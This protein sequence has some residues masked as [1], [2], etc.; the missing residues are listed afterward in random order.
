MPEIRFRDRQYTQLQGESV[1]EC[2][3]RHGVDAPHSCR[4]GVCQTCMMRATDGEL[5]A[6]AQ[7][8]L[9]PASRAQGFFLPCVCRENDDLVISDQSDSR[10][11]PAR[12]ISKEFLNPSVI[13]LQL[14]VE[15]DDF[16]YHAGQFV[17]VRREDRLTRSYSLASLPSAPYLELHV[18]YIQDGR[19]SGWIRDRLQPGD[20]L[21]VSE[22]AGEC[23]YMAEDR[24]LPILLVGTGSGLAPLLGVVQDALRQGHSGQ[25][26]LFHGARS[27]Q[28]LYLVDELRQL[29][30]EAANFSYH[31]CVSREQ[32]ADTTVRN[33]RASDLALADHPELK[34]W[35][36][37]LCGNP[38]MVNNTRKKVF[39]AGAAMQQIHVD[40]FVLGHD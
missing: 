23:I 18:R 25:I 8:G 35:T 40:P 21:Q 30:T 27:V 22:P 31:P 14:E 3:L 7:Q 39:L 1:L 37:Y 29:Q 10:F 4:N 12:V 6:V 13:R 17:H 38:E 9:K 5:P 11:Y 15:A 24:S 20:R 36:V 34:G 33:G 19:M 26:E 32:A 2:L 28:D 16:S